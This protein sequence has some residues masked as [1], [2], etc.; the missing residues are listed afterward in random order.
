[1][2]SNAILVVDDDPDL[3]MLMANALK[4]LQFRVECANTLNEG[5][6]KIM[7]FHPFLIFLDH[8]LPDGKGINFINRLKEKIK[9]KVIVMSADPS[10]LLRSIAIKRGA[11]DFIEKPFKTDALKGILRLV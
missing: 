6:E 1:M 4:R 7:E 10:P 3:C 8:N 11:D 2:N 9:C 5:I